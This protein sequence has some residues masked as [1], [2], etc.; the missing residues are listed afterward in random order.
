MVCA[1]V[2]AKVSDPTEAPPRVTVSACE[3]LKRILV[4]AADIVALFTNDPPTASVEVPRV[5]EPELIVKSFVVVASRSSNVH[6]PPEPLKMI[7]LNDEVLGL[8][9][10]PEVVAVKLTVEVPAVKSAPVPVSQLPPIAIL[11]A[12]TDDAT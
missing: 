5:T 9:T 1:P 12:V 11:S 3:E 7:L 2:P 4:D 8:T 6:A 10:L